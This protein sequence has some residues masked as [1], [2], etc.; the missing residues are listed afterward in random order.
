MFI[1]FYK[2]LIHKLIIIVSHREFKNYIYFLI[3]KYKF[4]SLYFINTLG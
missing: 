1:M 3:M 2:D 4:Y